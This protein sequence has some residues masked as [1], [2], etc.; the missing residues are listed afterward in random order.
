MVEILTFTSYDR[1]SG[2][3]C[4]PFSVTTPSAFVPFRTGASITAFC[5]L[6]TRAISVSGTEIRTFS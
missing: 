1:D 5:P 4:T 6:A 3:A 2:L